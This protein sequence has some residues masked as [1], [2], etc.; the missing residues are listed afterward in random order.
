MLIISGSDIDT[1]ILGPRHVTRNDYFDHFPDFLLANAP[2]GAIEELVPVRE[3]SAPIIKLKYSDIDLD[4]AY[5]PLERSSVLPDLDIKDDS[6]IRNLDDA[7]VRNFNGVRVAAEII[8]LIP[9]QKSFGHALRTIKLWAK[10]RG[11]DAAIVGYPGGI[12]W[13]IMVARICQL[14]PNACGSVLVSKVFHLMRIWTWSYKNPVE[15]RERRYAGVGTH[16]QWNPVQEKGD[17]A[18]LMPVITPSYPC[19]CTTHTVSRSTLRIIMNEL[20][21]AEKIVMHIARGEKK[22]ADLFEPNT[23]FVSDYKYYLAV[24]SSSNTKDGLKKWSSFVNSRVRHL[25]T[26]IVT[27]DNDVVLAAPYVDGFTRVHQCQT[28][29]EKEKILGGN[30]SFQ[31]KETTAVSAEDIAKPQEPLEVGSHN[32]VDH[33]LHE[34]QQAATH[35]ENGP[36]GPDDTVPMPDAGSVKTELD[37]TPQ[38]EEP[39]TI[40][41]T[42]FYIG[43]EIQKGTKQLNLQNIA[44]DFKWSCMNNPQFDKEMMMLRVTLVKRSE[45]SHQIKTLG[46]C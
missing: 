3:T 25:A 29:E 11:I 30:L 44:E 42:T 14:Y 33:K 12:A 43:L 27:A 40:Y 21:R 28:R 23:F 16:R 18:H 36:P 15:L 35:T 2:K 31:V 41:T 13:A 39:I 4:L 34:E 26:H 22:W 1:L 8:G 5:V 6:L 38:Q 32:G 45:C 24:I 20:D 46:R 9:Q 37:A 19:M 7:A 17:A 10:R